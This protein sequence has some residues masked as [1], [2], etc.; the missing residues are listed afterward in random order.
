M[1]YLTVKNFETF[2]HYQNK[3]GAPAWI[4]LHKALLHDYEFQSLTDKAKAHLMLIWLLV[5]QRKDRSIPDDA[6]WVQRAI[7]ASD[8]VDLQSLI[9][10]GWLVALEPIPETTLEA[11]PESGLE[12]NRIEEKRIED[13]NRNSDLVREDDVISVQE[14]LE[15]WNELCPP[16]GLAAVRELSASRKQKASARIREHP[17]VAFWNDVFREIKRSAFLRGMG[18]AN[19]KEPWRANFDWLIENDTNCIKVAEGRYGK[20][21][22][23]ASSTGG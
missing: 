17:K 5:S 7:G 22:G 18:P 20:S 11:S 2:Q 3:G 14:L 4:K 13:Q 16:V 8:K 12:Q 15:S 19:G 21:D 6:G 1:R 23:R 10:A 9:S